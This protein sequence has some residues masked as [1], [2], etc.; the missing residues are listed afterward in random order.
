MINDKFDYKLKVIAGVHKNAE[1]T[2]EANTE[3][4]I[5]SGDDCDIILIDDGVKEKHLSLCL[6][7][8]SVWLEKNGAPVFLDGK[9]FQDTEAILESFQ[10]VTVGD[11]H[12]AI[13]PENMEW[14]LLAPPV[15]E[16]RPDRSDST[17]LTKGQ[18]SHKIKRFRLREYF[19]MF[20]EVVSNANIKVLVVAVGFI[21]LFFSFWIDFII[22]GTAAKANETTPASYKKE[23]SVSRSGLILSV[24]KV[25]TQIR[26]GTMVGAGVEEPQVDVKTETLVDTDSTEVVREVLQKNWGENLTETPQQNGEIKYQGFDPQN[27]M[28]LRLN[29]N[30]ENDGTLSAN[31]YTLHKKQRKEIVAELGDIIRVKVFSADEM[32]DLCRKTL[33]KKKIKKPNAHFNMKNNAITL[34]G[35]SDDHKIISEI[36]R[37]ITDSLPDVIVNNQVE[38]TPQKLNIVGVSV[39]GVAHV[40]LSDGSKVF[41]GGRLKNGCIVDNI[42]QNRIQLKCHGEIIYYNIGDD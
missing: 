22:S 25:M 21:F 5:G 8:E 14:P 35:E 7:E 17:A 20:Y 29:L 33:Q 27:Q 18:K 3:Y 28:D 6:S 30:K 1:L 16:H 36:E 2:L 38:Y 9:A 26:E 41:P 31:G 32:E 37:L 13:G 4:E 34:K 10:I 42:L 40:K 19:E 39:N 11:A 15:L 24:I 23:A 12:F